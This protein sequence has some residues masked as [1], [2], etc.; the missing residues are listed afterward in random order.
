[1][2]T[3][4]RRHLD[5]LLSEASTRTVLLRLASRIVRG[6]DAEDALHEG[7]AHALAAIDSFRGESALLTWL[8]RIVLNA[9]LMYA[10][11]HR[12]QPPSPVVPTRNLSGSASAAPDEDYERGQEMS[13]LRHAFAQLPG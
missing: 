10:R 11:K 9:S 12:R 7:L 2:N 1:M 6:H 4:R 5:E 13:R 8:H 3:E